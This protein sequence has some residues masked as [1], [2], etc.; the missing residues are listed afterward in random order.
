MAIS[1]NEKFA[2]VVECLTNKLIVI[3]LENEK[4]RHIVNGPK[5]DES[6]EYRCHEI[7]CTA[8]GAADI[9]LLEDKNLAL[10]PF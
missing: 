10:I 1:D 8:S 7:Q 2:Y 5:L 9:A 4:I 6:R 3:D